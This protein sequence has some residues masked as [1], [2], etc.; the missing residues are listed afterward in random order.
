[1]NYLTLW[2]FFNDL[3]FFTAVGPYIIRFISSTNFIPWVAP[4]LKMLSKLLIK[5][6]KSIGKRGDL[7]GIPV[8][9]AIGGLQ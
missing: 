5:K 1:M 3:Q 6:R 7:C 4:F 8:V 2:A 9:T